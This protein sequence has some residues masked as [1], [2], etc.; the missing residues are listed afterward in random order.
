MTGF[1]SIGKESEEA[2]KDF[3]PKG[4]ERRHPRSRPCPGWSSTASIIARGLARVSR[5]RS[6]WPGTSGTEA[7]FERAFSSRAIARVILFA[8]L[9]SLVK[10]FNGNFVASTR[11]LFGI[12]KR[13]SGP[14]VA[15]AGA[16]AVRDADRR[17]GP[18]DGADGGGRLPGRRVAGSGDRGGL[19][20]GRRRLAGDVRVLP[21]PNPREPPGRRTRSSGGRD[22]RRRVRRDRRDEGPSDRPGQLL[23]LRVDRVRTLVRARRDLL[24]YAAARAASR[25]ARQLT[26]EG[27]DANIRRT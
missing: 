2:R 13:E 1:E 18:D 17:R 19:A 8:A 11:L 14:P 24:E 4:F 16:S 10:I 25:A 6:S 20:R 3:D 15:R 21:S 26:G 7:A 27:G 22:R 5:G 23:A 12:G 9:L